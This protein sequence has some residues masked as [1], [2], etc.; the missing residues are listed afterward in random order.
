MKLLKQECV[1]PPGKRNHKKKLTLLCEH[2]GTTVTRTSWSGVKAK[3]CG[4]LPNVTHGK[5][6]HPLYG[7]WHG[8]K[9]RCLNPNGKNKVR[10]FERGVSVCDLWLSFEPFYKWAIENGWQPGL[11]L[12]RIDNNQGYSPANCRFVN[13]EQSNRNRTNT[14]ITANQAAEAKRLIGL[15]L[16]NLEISNALGIKRTTIKNI[17]KGAAWKNTPTL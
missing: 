14:T 7:V 10:Y 12:D 9:D 11:I 13:I 5:S 15:G 3:S 2:C 16:T 17:R 8:L 6:K 4:C 1:G